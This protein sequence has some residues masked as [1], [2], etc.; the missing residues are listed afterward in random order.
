MVCVATDVLDET[1]RRAAARAELSAS[2]DRLCCLEREV[3]C[4]TV[5]AVAILWWDNVSRCYLASL[6]SAP[7]Q[8]SRRL[9]AVSRGHGWSDGGNTESDRWHRSVD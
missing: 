7:F 6:A 3:E 5:A 1:L 2:H 4:G 8:R 9:G